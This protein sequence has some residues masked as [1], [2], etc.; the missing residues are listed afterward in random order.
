MN[1]PTQATPEIRLNSGESPAESLTTPKST[2][3][4]PSAALASLDNARENLEAA[5]SCLPISLIWFVTSLA[6]QQTALAYHELRQQLE[7]TRQADS[8][9]EGKP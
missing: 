5:L 1:T 2:P 8:L 9:M 4:N 3:P 6:Q 7:L